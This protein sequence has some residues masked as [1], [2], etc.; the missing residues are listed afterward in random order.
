MDGDHVATIEFFERVYHPSSLW[1]IMLTTHRQESVPPAL[2]KDK[3][4]IHGEDISVHQAWQSTLYVTNFPE[5]YDDG[6]IRELFG[7]VHALT[8]LRTHRAN[9]VR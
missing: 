4:R 7:K 1:Y 8:L 9:P 5:K 2:T 3:K 6:S